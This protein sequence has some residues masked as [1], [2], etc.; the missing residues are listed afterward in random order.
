MVISGQEEEQRKTCIDFL[1]QIKN[2][3]YSN[4]L[5]EEQRKSLF[6]FLFFFMNSASSNANLREGRAD[7]R[8]GV[9][10]VLDS[11]NFCLVT[12]VISANPLRL[13]INGGRS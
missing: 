2:Y 8:M 4:S 1:A 5:E 3:F 13:I 11:F 10:E 6:L 9:S 7:Q 12:Q